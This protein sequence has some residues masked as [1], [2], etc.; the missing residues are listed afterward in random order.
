MPSAARR[1]HS[2]VPMPP[3]PPVTNATR[4]RRLLGNLLTPPLT[5]APAAG[6]VPAVIETHAEAGRLHA[7]IAELATF[8]DD[9]AAGGS[10]RG[11]YPPTFARALDRVIAWME[12][13]GLQTRLDAVGNLYGSWPGGD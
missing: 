3:L 9:V 11:V 10:T 6:S 13:A 5:P 12:A 8:N 2:T 1:R 4:P 7:A